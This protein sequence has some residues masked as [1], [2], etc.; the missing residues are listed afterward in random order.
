MKTYH[1]IDEPVI[2]D[3]GAGRISEKRG[4]LSVDLDVAA[5]SHEDREQATQLLREIADKLDEKNNPES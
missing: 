5:M 4:N 1:V 3:A 2:C